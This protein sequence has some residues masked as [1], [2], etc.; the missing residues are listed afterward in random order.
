MGGN[1]FLA[2]LKISAPPCRNDSFGTEESFDANQSLFYLWLRYRDFFIV[3]W[4]RVLAGVWRRREAWVRT[5][6][7]IFAYVRMVEGT[8][9]A[10]SVQILVL[11]PNIAEIR[12]RVRLG[13]QSLFSAATWRQ[14]FPLFGVAPF[15]SSV[16]EPY[17]HLGGSTKY[18]AY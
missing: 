7:E 9:W 2:V 1:T 17:F 16:L 5:I 4:V 6:F 13:W 10:V 8:V 14:K 18:K 15:H 11:Y 3:W 12:V